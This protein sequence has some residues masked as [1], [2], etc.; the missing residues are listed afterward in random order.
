MHQFR[1]NLTQEEADALE[2]HADEI[3]GSVSFLIR[4]WIAQAL[5]SGMRLAPQECPIPRGEEKIRV[6]FTL[7]PEAIEWLGGKDAVVGK[8]QR[9]VREMLGMITNP[10][11]ALYPVINHSPV[12]PTSRSQ[13]A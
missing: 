11:T 13:A 3:W 2:R 6:H 5:R 9:I 8:A 12:L 7:P 1:I 4:A 10:A